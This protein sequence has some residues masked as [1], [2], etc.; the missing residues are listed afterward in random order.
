M[1][2]KVW[3]IGGT[4][5][6]ATIAKMLAESAIPLVITVTTLTAQALYNNDAATVVVGCMDGAQMARFCQHYQI[7][8]VIDASH[9]YA[10]EVSRQAIAVATELN[11]PYLRYERTPYQPSAIQQQN[12]KILELDSFEQL[13]TGNYLTAQRVL[14]TVGC[15]ALPLFQPWQ[16]RATLF[17]RILPKVQSLEMAIAAGFTGDRLI[18][19]R[20]PISLATE[21]ALWQQWNISLVV[22]KASG[23]AGGE[24]T[25]RQVAATLSIP[26]IIISRPSMSYP[27][28][29]FDLADVLAFCKLALNS[30]L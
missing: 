17:A 16:Q 9:P 23:Q 12:S 5:D 25:K 19:I 26:L 30:Q 4:G 14:L 3:L 24:D 18:A 7:K 11:I 6:S 13:L 29:T 28:Q 10:T 8:G 1:L 21:M 20:P 27:Q 2:Q 22:T 15:K